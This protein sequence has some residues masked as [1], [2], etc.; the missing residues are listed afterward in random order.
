MPFKKVAQ[1]IIKQSFRT[2]VFIDDEF[3]EPYQNFPDSKKFDF[4]RKMYEN[5]R[6]NSCSLEIYNY[7]NFKNWDNIKEYHLKKKDLIILDWVL[8]VQDPFYNDSLRILENAVYTENLHFVCIYTNTEKTDIPEKIIYRIN[9]YFSNCEVSKYKQ[10]IDKLEKK[11]EELNVDIDQVKNSL[12]IKLKELDLEKNK[13]D[14]TTQ[15]LQDV[16]DLLDQVDP[17]IYD[18]INAEIFQESS[19]NYK[20]TLIKIGFLLND[21]IVGTNELDTSI[22]N[23]VDNSMII[24]NTVIKIFNKRVIDPSELH[25]N[26]SSALLDGTNN[27]MT[28]LGLEIRN[29][30][31]E[32]SAFIGKEIDSIDEKAFFHHESRIKPRE[33][34]F[35]FL[36]LIW[37]EQSSS[38]LLQK[39]P[40]IFTLLDD[41]KKIN[42][43][44]RELK[45]INWKDGKKQQHLARLN[46]HY[47]I[48]LTKRNENDQMRFGDIFEIYKKGSDY[49]LHPENIFLLN[50]TA[51][52]DCVF[53]EE[54]INSNF[55]FVKGNKDSLGKMLK[56]EDEE[57]NSYILYNKEIIVLKWITKP[58]NLNIPLKQNSIGNSIEVDYLGNRG[59]LKYICTLKENYCQR[60][61]NHSFAHASRVGIFFT[62]LRCIE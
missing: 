10:F 13:R 9:A 36:R 45:N 4:C 47:N 50:I 12:K 49:D 20:E 46:F 2:A 23:L 11:L 42:N 30:L 32:S 8:K 31:M 41:Y 60:I 61:A 51:Q 18:F 43:I 3:P 21:C 25:S 54:N 7:K 39:E 62:G 17:T 34:F 44:D 40:R 53:P 58:F 52:C 15:I 55:F 56:K 26:F 37:K 57:Y 14:H 35:D 33:A 27:F 38:F 19:S 22:K 16:K 6:N 48:L 29:L 5:F 59:Y 28:I 1:E 24:N